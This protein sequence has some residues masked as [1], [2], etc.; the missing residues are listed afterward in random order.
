[1]KKILAVAGRDIKSGTRDF[2][3]VYILIAPFLLALLLKALVP[4]AGSTTVNMAVPPD[5]EEDFV[6]YLER[7]GSVERVQEMETRVNRTD[8]IFGIVPEKGGDGYTVIRQGNETEGSLEMLRF[9]LNQ[10]A[11]P[12]IDLP[13]EVV[14]SDIG[15]KL[16]PL[17]QQG[18]NFLIVFCTIL[19]GMMIT[20]NLVEEKMSNTLSAIN[21][22]AVSKTQFVIGKSILGLAV[23]LIGAVG[24]MLIMGFE[25]INFGMTAITIACVS[26]ISMIIGFSIGVVNTEPI[27]AIAGMKMIFIPVF[28]SLFGAIFLPDKWHPVLYWSPFYWAYVSMDKIILQEAEWLVILRNCGVILLITA[29]IFTALSKRI[30]HGLR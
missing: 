10:R 28:A 30:R 5:A 23:P 27:G 22:T 15:W 8:D 20:L 24:I 19:G 11:N 25:G 14:V 6:I 3:A 26:L 16:S 4:A 12:E 21:V 2:I 17:K 7:Y 13:I 18:T 29:V 1:M 9:I